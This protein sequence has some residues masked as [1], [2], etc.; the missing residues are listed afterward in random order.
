M[1]R[2]DMYE[3]LRRSKANKPPKNITQKKSE[4]FL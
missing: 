1:E 4:K 3:E 2:T